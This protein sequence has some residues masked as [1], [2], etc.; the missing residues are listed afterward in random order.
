MNDG[1]VAIDQSVTIQSMTNG[2][3]QKH[4]QMERH[5]FSNAL[6]THLVA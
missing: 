3:M 4:T 6:Q 1:Q 2:Q 5:V